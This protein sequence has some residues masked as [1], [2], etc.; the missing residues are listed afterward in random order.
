MDKTDEVDNGTSGAKLRK[1]QRARPDSILTM[2]MRDKGYLLSTEVAER[3][4]VHKAT[5][6]RWIKEGFVEA[7]DFNGAYY[8]RW[9]S[10]VKHMGEVADVLGLT[11]EVD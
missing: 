8:V 10:V 5:L 2:K 9:D 6:Y 3:V 7:L 4:G 1:K 11:C